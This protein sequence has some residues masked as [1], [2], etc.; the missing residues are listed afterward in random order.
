MIPS[1]DMWSTDE[2]PPASPASAR[3]QPCQS[4]A[5]AARLNTVRAAAMIVHPDLTLP[6]GLDPEVIRLDKWLPIL[7]EMHH[8]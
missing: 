4:P 1:I 7:C 2:C 5:P 6:A 8:H 3:S